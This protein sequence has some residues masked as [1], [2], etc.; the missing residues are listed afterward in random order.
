MS[1]NNWD[2]FFANVWFFCYLNIDRQHDCAHTSIRYICFFKIEYPL[3][4]EA[5]I[6][7]LLNSESQAEGAIMALNCSGMILGTLPVRHDLP[8]SHILHFSLFVGYLDW[9]TEHICICQCWWNCGMS[10]VSPS[11]TPVK[12]RVN[13]VGSNWL[14]ASWTGLFTGRRRHKL[15]AS[16]VRCIMMRLLTFLQTFSLYPF[17]N[18]LLEGNWLDQALL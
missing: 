14:C 12:P 1:S 7:T 13:R 5:L 18:L 17:A 15:K 9:K 10:R 11:K 3:K 2:F 8:S 4:I 6:V 16:A